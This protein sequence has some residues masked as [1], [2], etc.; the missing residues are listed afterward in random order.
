[1][2]HEPLTEVWGLSQFPETAL[3]CPTP[4]A[5]LS[6]AEVPGMLLAANLFLVS[7]SELPENLWPGH[8]PAAW[9]DG[10]LR[11]GLEWMH[12]P[13]AA[14][15]ALEQQFQARLEAA[16]LSDLRERPLEDGWTHPADE[17][18]A[19]HFEERG[20]FAPTDLVWVFERLEAHHRRALVQCLGRLRAA[21][22][23]PRILELARRCLEDEDI[24]SRDI[25]VGALESWGTEG[26]IALLR[27]HVEERAW[28]ADSIAQIVREADTRASRD[29]K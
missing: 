9:T 7:P 24:E 3:V 10:A 27:A 1:M 4:R 17:T 12:S 6:R 11:A 21:A 22:S 28:L 26:A 16:L 18:L 25:A 5:E 14:E 20:S 15:R 23:S 8:L 19:K 29:H 13:E 2:S